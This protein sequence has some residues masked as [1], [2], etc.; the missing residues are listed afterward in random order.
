MQ[1][2]IDSEKAGA[3]YVC[4]SCRGP[5]ARTSE[6][7]R[8]EDCGTCYE[9]EDG[10]ADFSGGHYYDNFVPG[11]ELSA[12]QVAGLDEE[13]SGAVSRIQDFYLPLL[14]LLIRKSNAPIEP[15]RVLDCGCGNGLTVDLL[16]T[17][18]FETWGSDY[19]A[20][21]KWQWTSR[22]YRSRLSVADG[23]RLPFRDG[24]FDAVISSGVLEHIGVEE[25]GGERY[26]VR[27]L[28]DRDARRQA[29]LRELLRVLAPGG[30]IWIDFP[31]GAFPI[32]F[33]HGT[34]AGVGARW[35]SASE[36]F[37]PTIREVRRDLKAVAPR[38]IVKALSPHGRLGLKRIRKH[39]Y[40]RVLNLPARLYLWVMTLPG[41][42]LLA[43][44]RLNPFL[45]LEI[46]LKGA[47][48]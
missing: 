22:K 25:F 30:R 16:N 37:L 13:F 18:G 48:R 11:Q 14:R 6:L 7:L 28:P 17:G 35:H 43:G 36:G 5:L 42:S 21:R 38:F 1:N 27:P 26:V 40:G 44:T 39:W 10:I 47:G 31:N 4:P 9:L 46:E 23:S 12:E 33:W 24:Y 32:D 3:D 2:E 15:V 19:S 34:T 41:P 20:L 8:C 29:Y 45:V